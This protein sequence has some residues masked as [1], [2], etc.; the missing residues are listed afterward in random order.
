MVTSADD[1]HHVVPATA[2]TVGRAKPKFATVRFANQSDRRLVLGILYIVV[3][4]QV[5]KGV[6]I[7]GH[8]PTKSK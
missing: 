5:P 2:W 8:N 6:A 7:R 4:F 3:R 1:A